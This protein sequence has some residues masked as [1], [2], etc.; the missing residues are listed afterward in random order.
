MNSI[1]HWNPFRE[2]EVVHRRL[3]GIFNRTPMRRGDKQEFLA[4]TEW[5]P[6]VDISENDQTYT[7][8]VELPEM[9]R[10]DIKVSV[11][12]GVLSISGERKFEKEEKGRKYHRVERSYGSFVRSFALPDNADASQVN[13]Q[14]RDGVLAVDVQKS[15]K[16]RP[17]AI[18]VK[19]G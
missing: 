1:S 18:D 13:A 8:K 6:L 15:E 19:V 4:E 3:S 2:L 9:K 7:V 12:N 10:E 11:E 5:E 16:A 14:Y 17:R